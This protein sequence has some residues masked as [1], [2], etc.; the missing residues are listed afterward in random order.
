MDILEFKKQLE[1]ELAI[2]YRSLELSK[3]AT[4]PEIRNTIPMY[5]KEIE[6]LQI[7]INSVSKAIP[8]KPREHYNWCDFS[9]EERKEHSQWFCRKCGWEIGE[10]KEKSYCSECGQK[11]DWN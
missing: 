1:R 7:L 4:H 8:E 10:D 5:E 2:K 9:E 6:K 3:E 11:V